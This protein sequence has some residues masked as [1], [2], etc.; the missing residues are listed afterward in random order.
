MS[1][2][3]RRMQ[4]GQKSDYTREEKLV[5]ENK[6]LKREL[7]KLRNV[8]KRSDLERLEHLESLVNEQRQFDKEIKKKDSQRREKWACHSCHQGYM[9]PRIFARRDGDFY[10][11]VCD[12]SE[13]S[14][15]TRMKKLTADVDLTMKDE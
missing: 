2:K 6:K 12:N 11:R 8:L 10:Y 5:A 9:I 13:C 14:N 15:K 1:K 7:K 3:P 4:R